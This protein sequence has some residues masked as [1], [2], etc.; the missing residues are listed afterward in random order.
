MERCYQRTEPVGA[1][2]LFK[3]FRHL[4]ILSATF[5]FIS[6]GSAAVDDADS[7]DE[8]MNAVDA[9]VGT[10]R[11]APTSDFPGTP[12]TNPANPQGA[13]M[14]DQGVNQ[15]APS[16]CIA[17]TSLGLCSVCGPTGQPQA[18]P[19]DP[20]CPPVDCGIPGTYERVEENGDLVCQQIMGMAPVSP[21]CSGV[22]QCAAPEVAC[23]AVQRVEVARIV[24]A[25]PCQTL[26]G[27]MDSR[28][29][30]SW[31][32]RSTI[33]AIVQGDAKGP[34]DNGGAMFKCRAFAKLNRQRMRL[35]SV[36]RVWKAPKPI[37]NILLRHPVVNARPAIHF[38]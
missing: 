28:R 3:P 20:N 15:P 27:A 19:A 1:K 35:C 13:M 11:F 25:D 29:R 7:D 8:M 26:T 38:V 17:G 32:S 5:I 30:S 31:R 12:G 36:I 6:C 14:I 4:I 18:A 23:Q 34:M 24:G 16:G 22:G 10:S 33:C 37:A 9:L 2:P 21:P